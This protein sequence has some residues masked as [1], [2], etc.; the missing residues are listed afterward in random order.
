MF[1]WQFA[2]G[3]TILACKRYPRGG[4]GHGVFMAGDSLGAILRANTIRWV[5]VSKAG[6]FQ[7]SCVRSTR[8]GILAVLATAYP[9]A[10]AYSR[11]Y[12]QKSLAVAHGFGWSVLVHSLDPSCKNHLNAGT[13]IILAQSR[14]FR[15][16]GM[17]L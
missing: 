16:H 3:S 2:R 8:R 11:L 9:R 10:M 1:L 13:M 14:S 17:D 5:M 12:R 15:D 4:V 7:R 6:D